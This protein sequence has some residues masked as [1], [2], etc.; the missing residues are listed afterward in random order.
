MAPQKKQDRC[1]PGERSSSGEIPPRAQVQ[2]RESSFRYQR[3][4]PLTHVAPSRRSVLRLPVSPNLKLRRRIVAPILSV[5]QHQTRACDGGA[6]PF[7]PLQA[8][9][10]VRMATTLRT[11]YW[12]RCT[13]QRQ[14]LSCNGHTLMSFRSYGAT[15]CQY[16]TL[17]SLALRWRSHRT[18]YI[19]MLMPMLSTQYSTHSSTM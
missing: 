19:R 11:P 6:S 14:S 7:I 18:R 17:N 2:Y 10:I 12:T 4:H 5:A 15:G 13:L 8:R 3:V 1:N 9:T 16:S